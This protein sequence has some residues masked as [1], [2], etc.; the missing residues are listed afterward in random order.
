[1]A[2]FVFSAN[3][4]I[5]ILTSEPNGKTNSQS[6]N[7]ILSQE[8][9]DPWLLGWGYRRKITITNS[10]SSLTDYQVLVT[11]DTASL[12]SGG[13]MRSDCGDIR[14]T[15]SDG[16]TLL[17]YWLES[18]CNSTSTKLWVK[19]PSI[20]ASSTKAIYL[21]YGN[22]S[23]TS[24]S[25]GF[26][27]FIRFDDFENGLSS[28][29]DYVYYVEVINGK[30]V[31][32]RTYGWAE[33]LWYDIQPPYAIRSLAN[34][35][36]AYHK[37]LPYIIGNPHQTMVGCEFCSSSKYAFRVTDIGGN[38]LYCS[39]STFSFGEY[40]LV[41]A[42]VPNSSTTIFYINGTYGVTLNYEL[43]S[44]QK[45]GYSKATTPDNTET[46]TSEYIFI[47]NY[48]SPEPTYSIGEEEKRE[49]SIPSMPN[50][51][52]T[53]L[54]LTVPLILSIGTLIF[55]INVVEEMPNKSFKEIIIMIISIIVSISIFIMVFT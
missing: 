9:E 51:E 32:G 55:V 45:I 28:T 12:I 52:Q 23:A 10:T 26:Q 50:I 24:K 20:P 14:F 29:W 49:V 41:D 19:V 53:I 3:D 48:S 15:D 46:I 2:V 42:F 16:S 35:T 30:A 33:L 36:G 47:R 43:G 17:S 8:E 34:S 25:N 6:E 11:L 5:K 40:I 37:H 13:K 18:G 27:T 4:F 44:R 7:M 21:Y 1:V 22:P 31:L 54:S 39:A 38:Q